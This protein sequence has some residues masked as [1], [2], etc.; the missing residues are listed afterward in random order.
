MAGAAGAGVKF[1]AAYIDADA[2]LIDLWKVARWWSVIAFSDVPLAV[3]RNIFPAGTQEFPSTKS[4]D[5][6]HLVVLSCQ[7]SGLIA[8][9]AEVVRIF[10]FVGALL[11]LV[12]HSDFFI[13]AI[14]TVSFICYMVATYW[15]RA[16]RACPQGSKK[17]W[18]N[19]KF[20]WVT[21]DPGIFWFS[22]PLFGGSNKEWTN[23]I[24]EYATSDPGIFF[25]FG[26]CAFGKMGSKSRTPDDRSSR[27]S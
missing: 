1:F 22:A 2:H 12:V 8:N 16:P 10:E 6:L 7:V 14:Q 18:K 24:F 4:K 23:V 11:I 21:R 20:E 15:T 19:K 27:L 3:F 13:W 5:R 26:W 9:I 17:D 25:Y